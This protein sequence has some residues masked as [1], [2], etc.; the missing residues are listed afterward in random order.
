MKAIAL[1]SD[2]SGVLFDLLDKVTV[3]T[4]AFQIRNNRITSPEA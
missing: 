1:F 4:K 3:K 2:F